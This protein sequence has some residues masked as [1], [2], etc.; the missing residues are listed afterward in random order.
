VIAADDTM[1]NLA[2]TRIGATPDLGLTWHLPRLVG[3]RRALELMLLCDVFRAERA[4]EIG[5]VNLVVPAADFAR[6]VESLIDRLAR[7][8]ARAYAAVKRLS[9]AA[10][11]TP[12]GTQLSAERCELLAAIAGPEFRE[13]MQAIAERRAARFGLDGPL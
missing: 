4:R 10:L 3:E 2:Y 12:L 9:Y 13:G 1:F 6:E 7:G 11:D 8:P 5:L